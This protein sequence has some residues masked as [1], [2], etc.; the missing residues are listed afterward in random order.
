MQYLVANGTFSVGSKTILFDKNGNGRID[1]F[2]NIET[3]DE[4]DILND[5]L[6]ILSK[7]TIILID[8]S[9]YDN[10]EIGTAVNIGDTHIQLPNAY[11]ST[12]TGYVNNYTSPLVLQ[13]PDGK[14]QEAFV[15]KA[16]NGTRLDISTNL[17]D[18]TKTEGFKLQHPVTHIITDTIHV[19]AGFASI[20]PKK[21]AV[22]TMQK[23]NEVTIQVIIHESMHKYDGAVLCDISKEGNLM[24][25]ITSNKQTKIEKKTVSNADGSA[26]ILTTT[27][28]TSEPIP[29]VIPFE[30]KPVEEVKTGVGTPMGLFKSQ[31]NDIKR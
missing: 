9:I 7:N 18:P 16:I 1:D 23:T 2:K 15:I 10:W 31:W 12:L 24:H 27:T 17:T 30:Y 25:W 22:V 20:D 21:G 3:P 19:T 28:T 14:N 26:T 6:G 8:G 5:A 11:N 4:Y 29:I 13:N